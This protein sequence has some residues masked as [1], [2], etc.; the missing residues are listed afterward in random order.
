MAK[1]PETIFREAT[2][3]DLNRL[4]NTWWESISQNAIRNT[5]DILLCINGLFVA[6][7]Y[8][9]DGKTKPN[10]GQLYK[11]G[12]IRRKGKGIVFVAHP[13]NWSAVYRE[14]VALSKGVSLADADVDT[15]DFRSKYKTR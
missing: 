15:P 2:Y 3:P 14:L 10:K 8:K 1:K 13:Q 4:K 6:L 7:E 9:K 11:H 12:K 5:P